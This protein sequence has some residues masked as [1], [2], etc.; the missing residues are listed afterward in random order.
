MKVSSAA[1]LIASVTLSAA[2]ISLSLAS[3][4]S[5]LPTCIDLARQAGWKANHDIGR[6]R[7]IDVAYREGRCQTTDGKVYQGQHPKKK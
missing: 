4:A 2:A 5:S 1:I 3:A 7:F 6:K